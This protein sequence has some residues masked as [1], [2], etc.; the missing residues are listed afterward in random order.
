MN[1]TPRAASSSSSVT[2][3]LR[4]RPRRSKRQQTNTSN[5]RRRASRISRSG[6]A[7]VPSPRLRPGPRTRQ[8]TSQR[9]DVLPQLGEL[10]L[11]LLVECRD[12]GVHGCSARG[13]GHDD[14]PRLIG[15]PGFEDLIRGLQDA[16]GGAFGDGVTLLP[17]RGA[18]VSV[19]IDADGQLGTI[20]SSRRFKTDIRDMGCVSDRLMR[21]RPVSFHYKQAFAGGAMPIQY[22]L[23]AEEVAE[24]FPDLV[25]R[26]AT[27][28]PQ[29][30][31]YHKVD[32]MLLNEVQHQH[33]RL[34]WQAAQIEGQQRQ[35]ERLL[36]RFE[37]LEDR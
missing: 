36:E 8:P 10:V 18:A 17:P 21:L 4:L 26:Y 37:N 32:A 19:V 9:C 23:I 33:R 5:R 11:G 13:E 22:G 31:Q 34:E 16:L 25:V 35:I 12:S 15:G 7:V 28:E 29:T 20:S 27:G 30:V 24:V 1:A 3:C 6:R 14:A 2:R